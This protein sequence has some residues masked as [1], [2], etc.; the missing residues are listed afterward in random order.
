MATTT[1][2]TLATLKA[3]LGI[4]D[5]ASDTLLTEKITSASRSVDTFTGRRF[6]I[7]DDV[8]A[9]TYRP[10]GRTLWTDNG[11]HKL[12]VDDIAT[13]TGLIVETGSTSGGWTAVTDYDTDPENAAAQ[14]KAITGLLLPSGSWPCGRGQRVRVTAKWGWPAVPALVAEAALLQAQRLWSRKG[15]PEG[16]IGSA[17]WGAIRVSRLDPDVQKLLEDLQD[18]GIA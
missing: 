14:S 9:R 3:S 2:V 7:D 8:S 5:A 18:P 6:W 15:S 17:E 11:E 4:T 12:L 16:V 1:Y 10:T 13:A